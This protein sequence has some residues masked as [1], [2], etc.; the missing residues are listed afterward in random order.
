MKVLLFLFETNDDVVYKGE[1][2]CVRSMDS[3]LCPSSLIQMTNMLCHVGVLNKSN[4]K[5]QI[6]E[7]DT[8]LD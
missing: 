8:Y 4:V 6:L 5:W 3:N 7:L 1:S 2:A